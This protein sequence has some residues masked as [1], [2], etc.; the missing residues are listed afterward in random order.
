MN[1]WGYQKVVSQRLFA[2]NIINIAVGLLLG[3]GT[4]TQQG[5]ASQN[6]GW[7]LINIGIALIG[8]IVGGR[9]SQQADAMLPATLEKETRNLRRLLWINTGL[10][11]LYMVG[12]WF[13]SRRN[14]HKP[15]QQGMG[16]GIIIQGALLFIFDLL[17]VLPLHRPAQSSINPPTQTSAPGT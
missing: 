17:H 10:D 2:W 12:G 8:G 1:I 13:F 6:V 11:V 15:M 14:A 9:R 7:G 16:Y 5:I 3:R 4:P